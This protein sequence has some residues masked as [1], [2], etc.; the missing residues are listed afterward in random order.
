MQNLTDTSAWLSL[1]AHYQQIKSQRMSEL[2]TDDP[3][4]F[5][6]YSLEAAGLL[7]D[8]SKNRINQQTLQHLHDLADERQLP[9]A[10]EDLFTAKHCN[11]TEKRPALHTALRTQQQTPLLV[12]GV[13]ISPLIMDNLERMQVLSDDI[14]DGKWLGYKKQVITD[15]VNIGIGGSDLGP[16]ML[17][18]ALMPYANSSLRCHFVSNVDGTQIYDV[19]RIVNPATTLFIISSKSFTTVDTLQNA[20]TAITWW[21]HN[22]GSSEMMNKHFIAITGKPERAI[23]F[24]ITPENI[25]P[26]WDWVGGRFSV[27]SAVG[28]PLMLAIGADNFKDLLVGAN[29]MDEHFRHAPFQQNMP[30]ILGLLGIWYVNFF[31]K[32]SHAIVPY[33]Q[34]LRYFPDYLQQLCM[35][36]L[37]KS[38]QHQGE[39]VNYATSPVVWGGCGSNSQHSFHQLLHQGTSFVPVDF[40][41]SLKSHNPVDDHHQLLYAACVSQ[42]QALMKGCDGDAC[43]Q[44]NGNRPSNTLLMEKP[45]P[46]TLGALI[47]LYEHKVYVQ[48]V[49]WNINAFDQWGVELGK[50]LAQNI[51]T[52]LEG[53]SPLEKADPSTQALVTKFIES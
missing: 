2:F 32:Q 43:Q 14:R 36:S 13:D 50:Q 27:W 15:V 5:Q 33:N 41:V 28:L 39:P 40:I 47:A 10:I 52:A 49:I 9:Q 38:V 21:Q 12:D 11:S 20:K 34:Y 1:Q 30:V 45:T 16:K 25:F 31:K 29:A 46:N 26:V 48:S 24:G 44:V 22:V 23:E 4:R 17:T 42:S 53:N 3:D 19:L 51:V 8:Y 18:A 35:E 37:G 6:R 7:L